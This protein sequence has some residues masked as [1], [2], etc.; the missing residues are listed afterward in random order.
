M[1]ESLRTRPSMLLRIRDPKDS[2]SWTEFAEIYSPLIYRYARQHGLQDHDAADLTQEALIVVARAVRN[3]DYDPKMGTFRGWLFTVVHR[4]LL[5][6]IA[7][8]RRHPQGSGDTGILERLQQQPA[9]EDKAEELWD[10]T[11]EEHLF[12]WASA[13]VRPRVEDHTWQAFWRTA[14]E[15]QETRRVAADLMMTVA[16]VRLAKSRVMA[17]IKRLITEMELE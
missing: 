10:R 16:S 7:G 11:Y 8:Q 17:R 4:K 15:G 12:V 2:R 3:L 13:Q 9:P 1:T 6:L 14:V 5:N